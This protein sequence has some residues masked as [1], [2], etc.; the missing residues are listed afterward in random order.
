MPDLDPDLVQMLLTRAGY[1]QV[2]EREAE[3]FASLLW[4]RVQR[5]AQ[6][7]VVAEVAK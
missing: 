4:T 3:V 7:P 1:S 6:P 5:E 2:Q